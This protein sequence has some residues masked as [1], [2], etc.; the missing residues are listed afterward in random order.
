MTW[1]SSTVEEERARFVLEAKY[2][3]VPFA[4]LCRKY[5]ISRPTG[6]KWAYRYEEE[7]LGGLKD[8]S[9]RPHSCAHAT[10]WEAV[11]RILELRHLRE[12]GSRKILRRL[13][14]EEFE[15]PPSRKTIDR[16][17]HDYGLIIPTKPRR[18]RTHPGKPTGGMDRPNE[19][20]TA[21]FKGEFRM[22][23]GVMCYPLTVADG[24]T[25]FLIECY[26]LERLQIEATLR[27]FKRIF[28]E[29]GL[30]DSIRTDNGHPF[31]SQAIARL[32]QLS[33]FWV[34]LGITP[35]LIR[36]GK[37]QD[38]GRHERMHRTLKAR[39]ANPPRAS[40]RAQQQCFDDFR[41]MFNH[42]RPHEALDLDRPASHYQP[43]P[44]PYPKHLEPLTYPAHFEVRRVS[45]DSTIRWHSQKV[46]VSHLLSRLE[47]GLEEVGDGVWSVF[48]G[49][50]HLGWLDQVDFRIM[51]V[52]GNTRRR[53]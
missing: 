31:A 42:E 18:Q 27:R 43:S 49:P 10:S 4:E 50:L 37:P 46:F 45:Q 21:D 39:T 17:L 40:M 2:S 3:Y 22:K 5:Q 19:T 28:R 6:Y 32:S 30:P 1:R 29:Y 16:I 33:V 20:W 24:C 35:E 26:G 14:D 53:R 11:E 34:Q 47:V 25:R 41:H 9:H 13:K 15:D 48:F 23:N 7:G 44:R 51:D 12:W 8:R 36:P 52:Q 38:N